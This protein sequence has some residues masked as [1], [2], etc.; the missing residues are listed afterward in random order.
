LILFIVQGT[1]EALAVYA[2]INLLA[3]S[4]LSIFFKKIFFLN[5]FIYEIVIF[6]L[7]YG[8]AYLGANIYIKHSKMMITDDELIKLVLFSTWSGIISWIPFFK[9]PARVISIGLLAYFIYVTNRM[10]ISSNKK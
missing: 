8:L 4:F 9:W 7:I 6:S 3:N 5:T 1:R 10:K 2:A